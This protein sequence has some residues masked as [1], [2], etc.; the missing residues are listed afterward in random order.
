MDKSE[1]R[2][3]NAKKG[4]YNRGY[5]NKN[6]E[7]H[8]QNQENAEKKVI[9][10]D[11]WSRY[12]ISEKNEHEC[13]ESANFNLL[14]NNPISN[15]SF[16]KLKSEHTW[17]KDTRSLVELC[18]YFLLDLKLLSEG[19]LCVPFSKRQD[20]NLFSVSNY[21]LFLLFI[22]LLLNYLILAYGY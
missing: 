11:N 16:F 9:V 19:T 1:A 21:Y 10:P 7:Q 13:T 18:N 17:E 4:K 12:E 5:N 6:K 14:L 8:D 20:L 3:K 15:Y 2:K 22:F